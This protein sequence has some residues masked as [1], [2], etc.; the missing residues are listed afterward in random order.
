MATQ[1]RYDVAIVGGGPA[2]LTAGIWL[3]RFLHR[4]AIFDKGDP[5]NWKT[6]GVHGFL[7]HDGIR[8][9]LLRRRGRQECRRYGADLVDLP[10]T[11]AEAQGP[12]SLYLATEEGHEFNARRLLLATGICDRWPEIPGLQRCFGTS[13]H[14]CPNC[15]GFESR[16]TPVVVLGAGERA[17]LV[18]LAMLTWTDQV[19]ICTHGASPTFDELTAAT[20][21][22]QEI[23]VDELP[24][25]CLLQTHR[26]VHHL[27]LIDGT[28]RRCEHIFLAMGQRG[29]DNLADQLGCRRDEN[30]FVIVDDHHHSTVWNVFAVGDLTPGPQ[31]AIRAAAEAAEA[32]LSI[33]HSLIP[34]DR[35]VHRRC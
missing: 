5:R 13:V 24:I 6:Q 8:P 25:D 15:D 22:R 14:T 18:A 27:Q 20:L 17:A 3:S 19:R 34:E 30:G 28:L 9:A 7:G 26:M 1:K 31:M 33:H 29:R 10:I 4:V 11:H 16:Q 32:S 23:P 21:R 2:G 12:E 35:R